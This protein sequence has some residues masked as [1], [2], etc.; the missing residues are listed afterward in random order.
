MKHF[1]SGHYSLTIAA[2]LK[3]PFSSNFITCYV[4]LS[5]L[6]QGFEQRGNVLK[7]SLDRSPC[8]LFFSL[9]YLLCTVAGMNKTPE[10]L[11]K[12]LQT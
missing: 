10:N 5:N 1:V 8:F 12:C 9:I 7:Y 4:R 2:K 11:I 6:L 3:F